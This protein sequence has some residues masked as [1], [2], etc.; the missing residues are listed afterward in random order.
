MSIQ[1][2]IYPLYLVSSPSYPSAGVTSLTFYSYPKVPLL[3]KN[4]LKQKTRHKLGIKTGLNVSKRAIEILSQIHC[5]E[6]PR[7]KGTWGGKGLYGLCF[8]IAVHYLRK[9]GKD[10]EKGRDL[11]ERDDA[12][13][14]KE[15]RLLALAPH[16]LLSLHAY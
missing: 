14:L 5:V 9:S 7:P 11:E 8:H 1:P 3:V 2:Y 10:L 13:A 16:S 15:C 12:E 4:I 6:T